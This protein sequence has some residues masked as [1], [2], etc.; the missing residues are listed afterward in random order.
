[1]PHYRGRSRI[2]IGENT[3]HGPG[4]YWV[5]SLPEFNAT[6]LT[7]LRSAIRGLRLCPDATK[8]VRRESLP[9][10]GRTIMGPSFGPE[11]SLA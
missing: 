3:S 6:H 2:N 1:M 11:R 10:Q 4:M 7:I 5:L 8:V 9:K